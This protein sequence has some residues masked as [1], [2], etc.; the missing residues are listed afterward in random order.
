LTPPRF[1]NIVPIQRD[2]LLLIGF[3]LP[4]DHMG[5]GISDDERMANMRR[6]LSSLQQ[7]T[8]QRFGFDLAAWHAYL[9]AHPAFGYNNL[10]AFAAV[11]QAVEEA[12]GDHERERLVKLLEELGW[13]Q[14]L[15]QLR[16]GAW[17][18]AIGLV[19]VYAVVFPLKWAGL[20]PDHMTW[21]TLTLTPAALL[22]SLGSLFVG[23]IWLR[24]RWWLV[25]VP[26]LVLCLAVMIGLTVA[27]LAR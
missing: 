6:G 19:L 22:G 18:C 25:W 21:I 2:M 3:R 20:M 5:L 10:D 14:L 26:A 27:R 13:Q 23:A 17:A 11:R 7:Q 24:H 16:F 15:P 4:G 9:L 1:W 12:I 8:K